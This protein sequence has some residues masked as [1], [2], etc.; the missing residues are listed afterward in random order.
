[1]NT[2]TRLGLSA[3]LIGLSAFG[4]FALAQPKPAPAKSAAAAPAATDAAACCGGAHEKGQ[5]PLHAKAEG[6]QCPMQARAKAGG[7]C[8]LAHVS[9][10]ADVKIETSKQGASI[11]LTAK[12][13]ADVQKVQELAQKV[14]KRVGEGGSC[15]MGH[16]GPDHQHQH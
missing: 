10:L 4:A 14:G 6:G 9:E 13:P 12:S 11:V 2:R 7:G 1:M 8:P 3:V 16:G 15:C 5:C